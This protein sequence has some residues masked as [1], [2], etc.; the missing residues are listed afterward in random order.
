MRNFSLVNVKHQPPCYNACS[1]LA[2]VGTARNSGGASVCVSKLQV[3][4]ALYNN[5]FSQ[6]VPPAAVATAA[7]A[8]QKP[9]GPSAD[10]RRSGGANSTRYHGK[11]TLNESM[12]NIR[13]HSESSYERPVPCWVNWEQMLNGES[14]VIERSVTGIRSMCIS[15]IGTVTM[16]C[17]NTLKVRKVRSQ[18]LRLRIM[19]RQ[20]WKSSTSTYHSFQDY[21]VTTSQWNIQALLSSK[22]ITSTLTKEQKLSRS[23]APKTWKHS[24]S[25]WFLTERY[26]TLCRCSGRDAVVRGDDISTLWL[27]RKAKFVPDANNQ[28]LQSAADKSVICLIIMWCHEATV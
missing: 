5:D 28:H 1:P 27:K 20:R 13:Y 8:A 18:H 4:L 2:L 14:T 17:F 22:T 11:S 7:V 26:F 10:S 15:W 6:I 24:T 19:F 16:A 3:W 25:K 23:T 12:L 9:R 21:E